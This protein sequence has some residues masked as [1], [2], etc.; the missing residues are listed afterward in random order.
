MSDQKFKQGDRVKYPTASGE[1]H[2]VVSAYHGDSVYSVSDDGWPHGKFASS[3]F[4]FE[5][6]MEAE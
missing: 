3:R 4:L 6:E 1:W 5:R 2:G